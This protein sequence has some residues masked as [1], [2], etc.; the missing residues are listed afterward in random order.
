MLDFEKIILCEE[1]SRG[2]TFSTLTEHLFPM[3][4][5]LRQ[6]KYLKNFLNT[7]KKS[8]DNG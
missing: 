5:P 8:V 2:Y 4:C 6:K 7:F 1:V 3:L